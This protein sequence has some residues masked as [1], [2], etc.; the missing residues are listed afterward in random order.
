MD[1]VIGK[2]RLGGIGSDGGDGGCDGTECSILTS[3]LVK[4]R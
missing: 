1:R 4:A 3:S 2:D